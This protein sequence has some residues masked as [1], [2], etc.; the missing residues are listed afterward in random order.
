MLAQS[1]EHDFRVVGLSPTLGIEN[2]LKNK[3]FFLKKEKSLSYD[4]SL[5][6]Q[7]MQQKAFN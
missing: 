6:C 4:K 2:Y 7:L 1:V 3:T 5:S